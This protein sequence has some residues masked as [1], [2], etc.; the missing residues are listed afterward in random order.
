MVEGA[1]AHAGQPSLWEREREL[2]ALDRAIAATLAGSSG[3][4]VIEGPSG[5]GRSRLIAETRLR[6][7]VAG[8]AVL[9]AR[10]SEFERDYPFGVVR[11]LFEPA[12]V[13]EAA[14]ERLGR[15]AAAA[16]RPVF[17]VASPSAEV[18]GESTFAA[19]HGL[20]WLTLNLS[21]E[22]PLLLA[23]DDVQWS[24]RASLRF[25]G[26]LA[27][28][29]D[30]APILIAVGL[31]DT[32]AGDDAALLA[33]LTVNPIAER[34]A[35]RPL[36]R[37]A[38][39]DVVRARLGE[40]TD[41]AFADACHESTGGNPLLLSELL[42][43][44]AAEGVPPDAG[45]VPVIVELGS[46]AVSRAVL[47][48]LGRLPPSA[49]AVARAMAVLGDGAATSTVAA[50]AGLDGAT[51]AEAVRDLVGAGIVRAEPPL[52]FVHPLARAAVYR[53]LAPGERDLSHERAA[54]ILLDHHAP[55]E[56]VAAHLL[57]VPRHGDDW[58]ADV[59]LAAA[60]SAF[61]KGAPDA[62]IASLRRA[63]AEPLEPEFRAEVAFELGRAQALMS[64]PD[65][66][67]ALR[68]AY[69]SAADPEVRGH[70]ADW[71]ACTL[72]YLDAPD[73][74]ADVA[75]EASATLPAELA[76]LARQLEAGELIS[77]FFGAGN[78]GGERLART[79]SH[80]TIDPALGPGATM[81]AA[82][83]ALAWAEAGGPADAVVAL[84]RAAL[85]D[86]TLVAADAGYL[87]VAAMLPLALADVDDAVEGWSAVRA[88]AH[89][90]G[91]V[92][93]N[94]AAQLWGG[95]TQFLRGELADAETE[96]RAALAS[97]SLWGVP[98]QAP[99]AA[100][101]LAELLVERG[102]VQ[103]ARDLLDAA[104]QPHGGSDGSV[105]VERAETR[106]LL[107]EGR[108]EEALTAADRLRDEAGWR[109]HPR[110]VPWRSLK[111]RALD[112][113]GRR[114]EAVALALDE[115]A[116]ARGWGSPGTVGRSLRVLGT[117]EREAG[118][119]HLAEACSVLE[120]A[121][122]RLERA[123]ALAALGE[124]L[125]R[126]RRPTEARTPLREALELAEISGATSLV[127]RVR[128]ELY[129]TGARPR[130]TALRGVGSL[131]ASERR[132]AYLAA[133]GVSNRDIAQQLY[134]TPKTVE[135]HLGSVYRKLDIES[136]RELPRALA[137]TG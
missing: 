11:Q 48:R 37:D 93:T 65:S 130:T 123:K 66:A 71:L 85:H 22:R 102:A 61:A 91:F 31:R 39:A 25:L 33:E 105:L 59:L 94:L 110:Y 32:E 24:D 74:A 124:A 54:R 47:L 68:E 86:S 10:G 8:L 7:A 135:V 63:L 28:R 82:V 87:V 125:R 73:E 57:A 119:A 21:A 126:A 26:Y 107:A 76:D 88:E 18:P 44:L 55:V 127:E 58:V 43:T 131:T 99:L 1:G 84:A 121:P 23:I 115:L 100:A 113:L 108:A 16:A 38:T 83:S 120:H 133:E 40:P 106:V 9:T 30:D 5:I 27:R 14:W 53:D 89:R 132:V 98:S 4:V 36:S 118:L 49:G 109:T 103:E 56:R 92:F 51:V 128:A 96:L 2:G 42:E 104:G 35:P 45:H 20:Y 46:R 134:V 80:R 129:A 122:A 15:G 19:L 64:L 70:A 67:E 60:R 101:L 81:L 29:L 111:A 62:A 6:A 13:A 97:A 17:D 116:G 52:G 90:S 95:Y 34:I 77:L 50:L 78:A 69:E 41:P 136:R 75:H 117:I 114:D 3:V 137:P 72:N 112:R 12:L 79:A